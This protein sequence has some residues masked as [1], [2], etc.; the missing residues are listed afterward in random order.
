[1]LVVGLV[2]MLGLMMTGMPIAFCFLLLNVIGTFLIW[3]GQPGLIQLILSMRDSVT[4]FTLMPLP[5]FILMGEVMFRSGIASRSI[6]ALDKWLGRLPGRL[7]LLA[8]GGG[9]L[10]AFL[11]GSNESSTA[12]LGSVLLPDMEKRGYKKPMIL[13]PILGSG[14]LAMMIPPSGMAVLLASIAQISVGKLLIAITIPGI[15][16]AFLYSTYVITRSRL[17]P[18]LAPA[19]DVSHVPLS[20]KLQDTVRYILPLGLILFMVIGFI[21]LGITTP[22]EAAASGAIA[23]FILAA[24]YRKL[25]WV[26]VKKSFRCTLEITVMMFMIIS[27]AVAFSQVLAFSGATKGLV[28]FT[29]SLP[30]SPILIVIAMMVVVLILGCVMSLVAIMMITLPVF[31]PTIVALGFDPIW[32]GVIF[33]L[34]MQ[35]GSTSPPVGLQLFVMRGVTPANYTM[36]DI[37]LA[38]LPFLGLDLITMSLLITF[39]SIALWLSSVVL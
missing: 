3:G 1:M 17:Q 39:P 6:D 30:L 11:S 22:T 2:I 33:L 10:F 12:L 31:L 23:S 7:S 35:M 37:Y 27:G 13:G 5:L 4:R 18:Y 16:M 19:Y 9:A 29:S 32:F 14:G 24:L 25:N 8:V 34:N 20:E 26:L 36:K 15:I 28:E 38:A 21:L